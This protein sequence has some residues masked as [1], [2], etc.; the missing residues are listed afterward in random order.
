MVPVR[1]DDGT[2]L[3]EMVVYKLLR[4]HRRASA[5]FSAELK[6]F[7]LTSAQY[8]TMVRLFEEGELSQNHLGRVTAM[9]AVTIQGVVQRLQSQGIVERL[10]HAS[11]RRR[12]MVRLTPSGRSAVK[13]LQAKVTK[14]NAAILAP[15]ASDERG[16]FLSL[17]KRLV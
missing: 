9:D 2:T 17:L 8:F 11:D 12:L 14:A 6:D 7:H 15:L 10:P 16:M 5:I 4:A 13:G 1:K 3:D